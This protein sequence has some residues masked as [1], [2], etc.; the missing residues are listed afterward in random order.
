MPFKRERFLLASISW[1]KIESVDAINSVGSRDLLLVFT[2]N[3]L[4]NCPSP[5][6]VNARTYNL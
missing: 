2:D 4:E 1:M 6:A 5:I 3:I